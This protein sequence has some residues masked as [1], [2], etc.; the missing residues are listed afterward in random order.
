VTADRQPDAARRRTQL[1]EL[2]ALAAILF[3]YLVGLALPRG[4]P[5]LILP[6]LELLLGGW[7]FWR[8]RRPAWRLAGAGRHALVVGGVTAALSAGLLAVAALL[9]W[10]AT[11]GQAS[12]IEAGA[13]V[14]LVPLAEELYFRG[15]LFGHLVQTVGRLVA[16]LLSSALFGLLHLPQ[17]TAPVMAGL[18]ALLCLAVLLSGGSLLWA[19][20]LHSSWNAASVLRASTS[21]RPAVVVLAVLLWLGLLARALLSRETR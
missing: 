2:S 16:A 19:V 11:V 1:V 15:L 10:R 7:L 12:L 5:L 13:L 9:P 3:G 20:G 6:S 18:S 8:W 21:A 14:L 17:G 4:W